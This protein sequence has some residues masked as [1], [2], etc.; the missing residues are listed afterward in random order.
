M[1]AIWL[2]SVP[3]LLFPHSLSRKVGG[4]KA[5]P[6]APGTR[7]LG[8]LRLRP[9]PVHKCPPHLEAAFHPPT[10]FSLSKERPRGQG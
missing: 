9:D 6:S 2:R 1:G 10:A 4:Q 3:V 7:C 5:A 8:L